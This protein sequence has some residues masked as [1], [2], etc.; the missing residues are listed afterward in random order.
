MIESGQCRSEVREGPFA[1]LAVPLTA[2]LQGLT[3]L[4]LSGALS[5]EQIE[6]GLAETIAVLLR[7]Y[8]P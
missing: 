4:A 5:T 6:D 2:S 3:V 7:G 1:R 8:A